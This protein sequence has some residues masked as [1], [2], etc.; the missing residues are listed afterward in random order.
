MTGVIR[1]PRPASSYV[2]HSGAGHMSAGLHEVVM[3]IEATMSAGGARVSAS[4]EDILHVS[5]ACCS[6][7]SFLLLKVALRVTVSWVGADM[8]DRL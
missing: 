4:S 7:V 2:P 1:G 5:F 3:S 6:G 8:C